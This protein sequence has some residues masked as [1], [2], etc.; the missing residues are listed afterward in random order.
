MIADRWRLLT[1]EIDGRK[2]KYAIPDDGRSIDD[3]TLGEIMA[4]PAITGPMM[5][6]EL[7]VSRSTPVEK[8]ET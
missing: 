6:A 7:V 1:L 2:T 3:L 8:P 5:L 4:A